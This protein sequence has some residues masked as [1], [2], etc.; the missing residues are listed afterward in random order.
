NKPIAVCEAEKTA[1]IASVYLPGFTW[2]AAGSKDGLTADKCRI[3]LGKKVILFPDLNAYPEWMTVATRYGFTVSDFHLKNSSDEEKK[4]GLDIADFL[5]KYSPKSFEH[6]PASWDQPC[7]RNP[8]NDYWRLVNWAE[9]LEAAYI[10]DN[11]K[12]YAAIL[13]ELEAAG[14]DGIPDDIMKQHAP[15]TLTFIND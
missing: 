13:I 15:G 7:E 14:F 1:M 4:E 3:L 6:Y 2:V 12:K 10:S 8:V 11:R 9:N 5:I